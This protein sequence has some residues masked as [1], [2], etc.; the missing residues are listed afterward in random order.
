[1]ELD[2]QTFV[3]KQGIWGFNLIALAKPC[4][5]AQYLYV[6]RNK[7]RVAPKVGARTLDLKDCC[8]SY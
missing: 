1:M 4:D 3:G 5:R 2:V 6:T 8:R 7:E